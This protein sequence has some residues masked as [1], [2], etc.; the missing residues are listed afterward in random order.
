MAETISKPRGRTAK[1]PS[2]KA[3]WRMA[4]A[5]GQTAKDAKFA[6]LDRVSPSALGF[7]S[8]GLGGETP[9]L[10]LPTTVDTETARGNLG[11]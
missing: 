1:V 11:T 6:K 7:V 3:K 5:E 9:I 4:A 10:T 2:G 8:W